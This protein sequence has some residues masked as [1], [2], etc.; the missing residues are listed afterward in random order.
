MYSVTFNGPKLGLDLIDADGK[1]CV[2]QAYAENADVISVGDHILSLNDKSL[3]ELKIRSHKDLAGWLQKNSARP[4]NM[5]LNRKVLVRR[6]FVPK[7]DCRAN[8][9]ALCRSR[10][11]PP[12]GRGLAQTQLAMEV[13][14]G[15]VMLRETDGTPTSKYIHDTGASHWRG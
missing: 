14:T 13:H 11:C 9:T 8:F 1:V 4:L 15:N 5:T 7:V 2:K 6:F 3:A 12:H 10:L